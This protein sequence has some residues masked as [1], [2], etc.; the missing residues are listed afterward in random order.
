MDDAKI[1]IF[2]PNKK[3][4]DAK[5]KSGLRTISV[6]LIMCFVLLHAPDVQAAEPACLICFV[7]VVQ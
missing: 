5:V 7:N 3:D 6:L 1:N 4:C 2:Q